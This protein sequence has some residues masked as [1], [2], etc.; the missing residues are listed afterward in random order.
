MKNSPPEMKSTVGA[1]QRTLS[2][3]RGENN[4][5]L[6]NKKQPLCQKNL[7]KDIPHGRGRLQYCTSLRIRTVHVL[8]LSKED[9]LHLDIRRH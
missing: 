8:Y 1:R 6:S 2:Y 5:Q 3:R 7:S 9:P 4:S